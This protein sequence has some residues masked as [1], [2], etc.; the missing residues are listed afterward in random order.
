LNLLS[1]LE[2]KRI[3]ITDAIRF[4]VILVIHLK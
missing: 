4:F 3:R 1:E 2:N